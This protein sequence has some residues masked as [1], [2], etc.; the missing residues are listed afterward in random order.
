M[1][2]LEAQKFAVL[3]GIQA[4]LNNS[5]YYKDDKV[6]I[7]GVCSGKVLIKSR[8]KALQTVQASRLTPMLRPLTDVTYKEKCELARMNPSYHITCI[9]NKRVIEHNIDVEHVPYLISKGFDVFGFIKSG[10]AIEV[11]TK[12]KP[13]K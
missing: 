10:Q 4:V 3:V 2:K 7:C 12:N 8:T 6:T 13:K 9:F 5:G 1:K 11:K